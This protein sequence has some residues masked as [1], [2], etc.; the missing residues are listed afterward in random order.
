MGGWKGPNIQKSA[1]VV[2]GWSLTDLQFV[3]FQIADYV[4][5]PTYQ[6]IQTKLQIDVYQMFWDAFDLLKQASRH[7]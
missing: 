1:Y 2:H 4:E 5:L 3:D 7:N 6:Y